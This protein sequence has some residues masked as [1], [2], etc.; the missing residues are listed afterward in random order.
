MQ[1][2]RDIG[3]KVWPNL[4]KEPSGDLGAGSGSLLDALKSLVPLAS[5]RL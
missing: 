5:S 2:R 1:Q 4:F 3:E